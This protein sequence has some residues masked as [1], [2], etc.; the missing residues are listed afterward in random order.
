MLQLHEI[1]SPRWLFRRGR[2]DRERVELQQGFAAGEMGLRVQVAWQHPEAAHGRFE[3][4]RESAVSS[5]CSGFRRRR[6]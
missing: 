5:L 4:K 6:T 1:A 2:A 3:V